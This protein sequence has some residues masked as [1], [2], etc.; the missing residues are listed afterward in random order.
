MLRI[1][2]LVLS[3]AIANV[4]AGDNF[5][6]DEL[7]CESNYG[8]NGPEFPCSGSLSTNYRCNN[9]F[10]NIVDTPFYNCSNIN[11][12]W[13]APRNNLTL[14]IEAANY[15]DFK[16]PFAVSLSSRLG[17]VPVYRVY[18]NGEEVLIPKTE[19]KQSV[20]TSDENY[21]VIL[22]FKGPPRFQLYGTFIEY[23]V[24]PVDTSTS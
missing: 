20:C 9:T 7:K 8:T 12:F 23:E 1:I 19:E 10:V 22:K 15:T 17:L 4:V 21:Q 3:L 6:S 24:A 11:I 18:S 2:I 5:E 13:D 14:T 16:R